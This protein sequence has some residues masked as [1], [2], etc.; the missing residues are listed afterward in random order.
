MYAGSAMVLNYSGPIQT[1]GETFNGTVQINSGTNIGIPL[2]CKK[3]KDGTHYNANDI[4]SQTGN[5]MTP[6]TIDG[7]VY[8]NFPMFD[9]PDGTVLTDGSNE[10]YVRQLRPRIV[11]AEASLSQCAN[12]TIGSAKETSDHTFFNY[13]VLKL[14]R[15]GAVL[16]NKLSNDPTKDRAFNGNKW[17]ASNDDDSDGVLNSLDMFPVDSSKNKDV[18]FDGVEDSL[19]ATLSEFQFNWTKHLDKSMFSAYEQNKLN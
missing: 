18:D 2:V 8:E 12:M 13:P 17:I 7:E 5:V 11:Y 9:I 15:V 1:S 4:C 3:V 19:D 10:Y 14:P 6:V 16:V